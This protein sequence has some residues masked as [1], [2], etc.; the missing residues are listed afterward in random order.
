MSAV[1]CLCRCRT[2][3]LAC[4]TR[5]RG[6][7]EPRPAARGGCQELERGITRWLISYLENFPA[8]CACSVTKYNYLRW[9]TYL[10]Q[11]VMRAPTKKVK[12]PIRFIRS[13]SR[14]GEK[15]KNGC[16][17]WM[18]RTSGKI[19]FGSRYN[20]GSQRAA[21]K[22]SIGMPFHFFLFIYFLVVV[23][24]YF[25]ESDLSPKTN[26]TS[27]F[28]TESYFTDAQLSIVRT[29]PVTWHIDFYQLFSKKMRE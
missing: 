15:D 24:A 10:A 28:P 25:S 21:S 1:I 22:A 5:R 3:G 9:S 18:D 8:L 14:L 20:P 17:Y 16:F 13:V 23:V 7:I 12:R 29:Y 26:Y 19:I 2:L 11:E 27:N 6:Q 4:H